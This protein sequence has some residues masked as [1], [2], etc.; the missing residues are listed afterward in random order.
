MELIANPRITISHSQIQRAACGRAWELS[1]VEGLEKK[2]SVEHEARFFGTVFHEAMKGMLPHLNDYTPQAL[3]KVAV[4]HAREAISTLR[5]PNKLNYRG[6][7]DFEYEDMLDRIDMGVVALLNYFVPKVANGR[8]RVATGMDVFGHRECTRCEGR[9]GYVEVDENGNDDWYS[10][11]KCDGQNLDKEL[12]IEWGFEYPVTDY[13]T[14]K[15]IIDVILIDMVTEEVI[16][17]DWKTRDAILPAM[18]ALI[19]G[20]LHLYAAIIDA[21]G[22]RVDS[23]SMW[24]VRRVPPAPATLVDGNSRPSKAASGIKATDKET[25]LATLPEKMLEQWSSESALAQIQSIKPEGHFH[26][27]TDAIITAVSNANAI[28]NLLAQANLLGYYRDLSAQDKP[29]P[30]QYSSHLCKG[31]PFL[32][33]CSDGLRYGGD[34]SQLV[35]SLY[36]RKEGYKQ[37]EIE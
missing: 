3:I 7:P 12:M 11:D 28:E 27:R 30:A 35:E 34:V 8:Y 26:M 16:I 32:P 9:G 4:H 24:Q 19:D 37:E 23:V 15:G 21:M 31:C 17:V 6:E 10:C 22:G 29:L 14:V 2:P 25:F 18:Q 5:I 13:V 36:D 20:Q 1:Y 33:L